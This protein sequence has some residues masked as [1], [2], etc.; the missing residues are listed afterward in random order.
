MKTVKELHIAV[1]QSLQKVASNQNRNFLDDEIDWALNV[2]Q[3]RYV[4]SRIKRTEQG[5]GFEL[6][7]KLLDDIS[8]LVNVSIS[9]PVIKSSTSSGYGVLPTDYFDLVDDKSKIYTDCNSNFNQLTETKTEYIS[10]VRF[11]NSTKTSNFYDTFKLTVNSQVIFNNSDYTKIYYSPFEKFL[12]V[13]LLLEDVNVYQFN[14]TIPVTV[15]W[16]SYK[17]LYR[18]DSFIIVSPISISGELIVDSSNAVTFTSTPSTYEVFKSLSERTIPNRLTNN[19][20]LSLVLNDPFAKSNIDSVVSRTFKDN[21]EVFFDST[22]IISEILID[23]VRKPRQISL[24]LNRMCELR[25]ST[26]QEIV[27][28]TVQYLMLITENP[29]YQIKNLDNKTNLE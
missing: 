13:N 5:T 23:Y 21:L 15:Y 7:Q 14:N 25:E 3:E 24:S 20:F 17:N 6:D 8:E 4:K 10:V 11:P 28:N 26:H 19:K 22:F 16:E 2:N 9:L 18:P 1:R 12:L 29:T 27:E